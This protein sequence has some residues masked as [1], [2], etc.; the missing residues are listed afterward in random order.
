[1]TIEVVEGDGEI[2]VGDEHL[3][4]HPGTWLHLPANTP[5]S[6]LASTPL[7]LLLTMVKHPRS[8]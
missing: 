7:T 4:G 3:E 5:H 8:S 6:V 2:C 1:V